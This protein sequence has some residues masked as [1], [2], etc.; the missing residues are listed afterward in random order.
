M[1]VSSIAWHI[2]RHECVTSTNDLAKKAVLAGAREGLVVIADRQTSGRGRHGRPWH[3]PQGNL[4]MSLVLTPEGGNRDF[5]AYSF[6]TSL[7]VRDAL[8]TWGR[9]EIPGEAI[10][11]KWPNDVLVNGAKISGILLE[12]EGESLI[13]GVGINLVSSPVDVPYPVTSV[14]ALCGQKLDTQQ[15]MRDVLAG[16]SRWRDVFLRQGLGGVL[17]AWRQYALRGPL[18]VK[19][20]NQVIKGT[21]VDID[22][23]GRLILCDEKGQN[24]CLSAGDVLRG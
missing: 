22:D 17:D 5:S 9:A 21:F 4:Y 23:W 12:A 8:H 6:M 13:V 11:L 14:E 7:A 24:H 19:A 2:E 18:T 1:T 20:H 16:L 3:S 15:A 10:T